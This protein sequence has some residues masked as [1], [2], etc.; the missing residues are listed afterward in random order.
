MRNILE[1]VNFTQVRENNLKLIF[2]LGVIIY[3]TFGILLHI[4]DTAYNDPLWLRLLILN[5]G[6]A[7]LIA[8][9]YSGFVKRHLVK[10]LF[11][12][13][14]IYNAHLYYLLFVNDFDSSYK[15]TLLVVIFA[16]II[17][18][19]DKKFNQLY[20][21][22]NTIT[23]VIILF[24]S[25]HFE[26]ENI[27]LAFLIFMV[28]VIGYFTNS[29]RID[30]F[31]QIK[32]RE[33]LLKSIT[34]NAYHGIFRVNMDDEIIYANDNFAKMLGYNSVLE[35]RTAKKALKLRNREKAR[36]INLMKINK[37]EIKNEEVEIIKR[38]GQILWVIIN[39]SPYS[40]ESGELLYYDGAIIDITERKKAEKELMLFSAAIDHSTTSVVITDRSGCVKYVNPFFT[41]VTGYSFDELFGQ[42]IQQHI[43]NEE[44]NKKIWHELKAGNM[45]KG[46]LTH[47]N[48]FGSEVTELASIAPIKNKNGTIMNF[49][50][51]SE[52]ITNRKIAEQELIKAKDQA[53]A[54]NKSQE[55]FLSTISHELRTPMNAV[56]GIT[57]LMLEDNPSAE[58]LE[59]LNILKFSANNLLAIINDILDLSK[60]EAGKLDFVPEDFSISG[61]INTIKTAHSL[62][63]SQKGIEIITKID[64]SVPEILVGDISRLNQILNNLVGNAVKFTDKGKINID[65]ICTKHTE[66]SV[67]LCLSVSDTGIG[68]PENRLEAIFESF[69]QASIYTNRIY[70]G[71]GLGLAITRRLVELQSGKISVKSKENEGSAF[72]F[73]LNFEKSNKTSLPSDSHHVQN[74]QGLK[75]IN[76]LLVEDNKVNQKVASKFLAKWDAQ[77]DFAENGVEALQ[78]IDQKDYD[79]I[80]MDLLMP[81]MD[82]YQATR[83]IRKKA[84]YDNLPIV[85]LTASAMS[86]EREN[87]FEAGVNDYVRKP[88]VPSELYHKI[89]K[90]TYRKGSHSKAS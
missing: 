48:K 23:Y 29:E 62:R 38:D 71:T 8:S 79:I 35:L 56:I 49:V 60:I 76:I 39:L 53:E 20:L 57:N 58:Q 11:A 25:G 37:E 32:N 7:T 55:Q 27:S 74:I 18:I 51:V 64:P 54:A 21:V 67:E 65:V 3:V 84:R 90:Y 10:I 45:W 77:V 24:A 15:L 9:I 87:A 66:S 78:M 16:S 5:F 40:D 46:E 52:D 42:K 86:H 88:F 72:T 17:F 14:Y 63:T 1:D 47:R 83:E 70:G 22:I 44:E 36:S 28:L 41:K 31:E 12:N 13:L 89:T 26:L 85:A 6:I 81:V 33:S 73:T 75:G 61:V 34:N 19:Q 82:G 50:I 43:L 4:S 2:G 59:N 68:I 30:A 80:L 69:S